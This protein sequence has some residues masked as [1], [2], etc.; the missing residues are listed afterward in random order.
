MFANSSLSTQERIRKR[1]E[2]DLVDEQRAQHS[3]AV[4]LVD[5]P[6]GVDFEVHRQTAEAR[7]QRIEELRAALGRLTAGQYGHCERCSLPVA[8]ERLE[9]LPHARYCVTCQ[10][11][12]DMSLAT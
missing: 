6:E 4:L 8:A 1:L 10:G 7:R 12:A 9:Y 3:A 11:A 5:A 2:R